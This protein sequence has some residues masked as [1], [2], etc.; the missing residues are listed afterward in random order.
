MYGGEISVESEPD[1]GATFRFNLI[2]K[3]SGAQTSELSTVSSQPATDK[4]LRILLAEDNEINQQLAIDTLKLWN[5]NV[6]IDIAVNGQVAVA[7]VV[8]SAYD[9]VLMDIQ[10]PVMDGNEA[11]R[12]I[13]NSQSSHSKVPIIAMTAHAF[14]EEHDRCLAN[15]MNDYVAKP[16]DPDVLI[17]KICKYA[18]IE[19]DNTAGNETNG[20]PMGV[21]GVFNIKTLFDACNCDKTELRR[22]FG[23]YTTSIPDD[24]SAL[25]AAYKNGDTEKVR[26]KHHALLTTFGYLGMTSAAEALEKATAEG[27]D[28]PQLLGQISAECQ[29]KLPMIKE[30]VES[31]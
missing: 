31:L 14:K 17:A 12:A 26:F 21:A 4:P 19:Q 1:Q 28:V 5:P 30:F 29:N 23:I 11:A 24:I 2:L 13:R 18:G 22:V 9:V 7:K 15:G 27:A 25:T 3:P 8:E 16:F 20:E 10:M 6:I